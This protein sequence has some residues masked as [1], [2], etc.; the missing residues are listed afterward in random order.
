M[1]VVKLLLNLGFETDSET[2]GMR[3]HLCMPAKIGMSNHQVLHQVNQ[4]DNHIH[5]ANKFEARNVTDNAKAQKAT[6]LPD[7]TDT[8]RITKSR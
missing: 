8:E 5:N 7:S 6:V 4:R 3:P 1:V 2:N